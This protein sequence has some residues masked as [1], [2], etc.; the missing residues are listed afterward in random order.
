MDPAWASLEPGSFLGAFEQCC[1][2]NRALRE[3]RIRGNEVFSNREAQ[4]N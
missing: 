1:K 2:R 3:W 4:L